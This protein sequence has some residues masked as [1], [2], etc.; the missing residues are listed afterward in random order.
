MVNKAKGLKGVIFMDYP[1]LIFLGGWQLGILSRS[2][3]LDTV[4]KV[5][6]TSELVS[7]C[8]DR[9]LCASDRTKPELW[10]S[11]FQQGKCACIPTRVSC[12]ISRR[13]EWLLGCVHHPAWWPLPQR[14][15]IWLCV[16]ILGSSGWR[17][18]LFGFH[19][20]NCCFFNKGPLL[21]LGMFYISSWR[22]I[23]HLLPGFQVY[24][25]SVVLAFCPPVTLLVALPVMSGWDFLLT[26]VGTGLDQCWPLLRGL[27]RELSL[28]S[29]AGEPRLLITTSFVLCWIPLTQ[30]YNILH[31]LLLRRCRCPIFLL[32]SGSLRAVNEDL[33]ATTLLPWW[34]ASLA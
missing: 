19:W 27:C 29:I 32:D 8:G 15:V 26:S 22:Y 17:Q 7:W 3:A 33:P 13:A 10:G 12:A 16:T 34:N 20:E 2:G 23:R 31:F 30:P 18:H 11:V 24:C 21:F 14:T 1:A 6:D 28:D 25:L 5:R 9:L 4:G